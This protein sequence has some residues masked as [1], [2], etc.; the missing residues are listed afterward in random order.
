MFIFSD[1]NL[2]LKNSIIAIVNFEL[3][4]YYRVKTMI[5]YAGGHALRLN[6]VSVMTNIIICQK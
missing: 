3:N 6:E 2:P 1:E 5:E 4:D